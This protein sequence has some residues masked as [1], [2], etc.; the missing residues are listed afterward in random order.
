MSSPLDDRH[1]AADAPEPIA[2]IG[3]GCRFPGAPSVEAFWEPLRDG[4]DAI[5]DVPTD[6]YLK[7]DELLVPHT[8]RARKIATRCGGFLDRIDRFDPYA[9]N[10]SPREARF[11]DPQQRLPLETAWEALE[12][13]GQDQRRLAGSR[14]GVYVGLWTGDYE[15]RMF[16]AARDFGFWMTTGGGRYA[17]SSRLSFT[18]DFQ[19]PSLTIDTAC[20]SSLVTVHVACQALR[21]GEC[22]LALAG[23][24]N[25]ILQ[26]EVTIAYSAGGALSPDGR[27]K[28]GDASADGYVRS[29]GVGV[30]VLKPLSRA[31]AGGDRIA[32]VIRG[33]AVNH[34]GQTGGSLIA[35]G[36]EVQVQVRLLREALASAGI[37]PADID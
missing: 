24:A 26:P 7:L 29:E 15:T 33:S 8:G 13:A 23:G 36:E 34:N 37:A 6:R 9:F 17:A 11:I 27:C 19:G 1:S 20:S 32:A 28:F 22:D 12:D 31:L 21:M 14:T 10:I 2:V 30:L 5:G 16:R 4:R 18:F 3:M 25:V 35:P